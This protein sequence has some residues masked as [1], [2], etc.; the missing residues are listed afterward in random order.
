MVNKTALALWE[1]SRSGSSLDLRNYTVPNSVI[2][3]ASIFNL[4]KAPSTVS[5]EQVPTLGTKIHTH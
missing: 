4:N 5:P 3:G 2:L 1:F